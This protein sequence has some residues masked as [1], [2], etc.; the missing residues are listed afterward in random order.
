MKFLTME[1]VADGNGAGKC[2][3]FSML[4]RYASSLT[5]KRC[6][7]TLADPALLPQYTTSP[8]AR[9][10]LVINLHRLDAF[11]SS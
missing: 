10:A 1:P 8:A 6:S 4:H 9:A 2:M 7:G 11:P 5:D 3:H